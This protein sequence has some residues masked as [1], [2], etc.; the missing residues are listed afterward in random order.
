MRFQDY[1]IESTEQVCN[2]LIRNVRAIPADKLEWKP[3]GDG[4]TSLDIL[5]ECAQSP[6]WFIG[7]L[8]A[9]ARP[10]FK[11]EA[12][13][14]MMAARKTWTTVDECVRVMNE[15]LQQLFAAVRELSDADLDIR[16]TL[17]FGGGMVRSLAD[18]AH[19]QYWNANYHLGQICYIQLLLGD[20][21]MH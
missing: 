2:D 12:F 1:A 13:Q 8:K 17:P 5:Q 18:M 20:K 16:I 21:D 10:D 19:G 9:R 7:I 15:N 4:R 14:E 3:M 6:S 11:P